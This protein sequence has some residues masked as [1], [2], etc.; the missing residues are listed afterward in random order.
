MSL[1][2]FVASRLSRPAGRV[3]DAPIR[4][5]VQETLREGGYAS[6]AEVQALRDEVKDL[7]GRAEALDKRIG[8]LVRKADAARADADAARVAVSLARAEAAAAKATAESASAAAGDAAQ[9]AAAPR[10]EPAPD[11]RIAELEARLAALSEQLTAPR[12]TPAAPPVVAAPAAA[13]P[14]DVS[15]GGCKVPGCAEPL[16]SKGFCSAHYQQWRRGTLRGFE[17]AAT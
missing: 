2:D 1:S 3:L 11:P 10:P 13:P 5:L 14:A 9:A 16:R 6:P 8:E 12:S 15:K 17:S 4:S 7:R